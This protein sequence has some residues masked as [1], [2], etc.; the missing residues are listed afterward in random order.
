MAKIDLESLV[1]RYRK[2]LEG[3]ADVTGKVG[4]RISGMTQALGRSVKNFLP[5]GMNAVSGMAQKVGGS[6]KDVAGKMKG[7]VGGLPDY[8]KGAGAN[9]L[10]EYGIEG[11]KKTANAAADILINKPLQDKSD[12]L[13]EN[14]RTSEAMY[15]AN[16]K[17]RKSESDLL[18]QLQALSSEEMLSSSQ[19]SEAAKL[20]EELGASYSDLGISI[21]ETTGKITGLD[22]AMLKVGKK[23]HKDETGDL[24]RQ[25]KDMRA[26]YDSYNEIINADGFWNNVFSGGKSSDAAMKA[27]QDQAAL[28]EKMMALQKKLHALKKKDPEKEFAAKKQEAEKKQFNAKYYDREHGVSEAIARAEQSGLYSDEQISAMKK[29]AAGYISKKNAGDPASEAAYRDL[30]NLMKDAGLGAMAR[31]GTGDRQ[32]EAS[33]DQVSKR[34]AKSE[35]KANAFLKNEEFNN[36]YQELINQGLTDEAERLKLINELEQKGIRLKKEKVDAILAERKNLQKAKDAEEEKKK[37]EEGRKNLNEQLKGKA[38][39]LKDT[40]MRNAGYGR[41]AAQE[42]ALRNAEKTKGSALTEKEKARVIKNADLEWDMEHREAPQL[43]NLAIKTN[44]LTSRGG[45]ATGAVM[46]DKDAVNRRLVEETRK[47][48]EIL[49][50]ISK[51]VDDIGKF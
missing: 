8:A 27:A 13:A 16:E 34:D 15:E 21:D 9:V 40:A 19:K 20:I 12:S 25:L 45:F 4:S 44:S 11:A 43:G 30:D 29:N 23:Q 50:Q 38:E 33:A 18:N 28:T 42:K 36:K 6:I 10:A 47:M 31:T 46:P 17:R 51:K 7:K 14:V 2:A 39:T 32:F 37:A 41:E 24:E 49:G 3:V 35:E 1:I 5:K 26:Q 22:E 48:N